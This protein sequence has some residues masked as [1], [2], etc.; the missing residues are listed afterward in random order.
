[1][2]GLQSELQN[3]GSIATINCESLAAV[4]WKKRVV[5][6]NND[7]AGIKINILEK[8]LKKLRV[9]ERCRYVSSNKKDKKNTE[10]RLLSYDKLLE[11]ETQ[12]SLFL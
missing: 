8:S 1:M 4:E 12:Q 3:Q 5:T 10:L 2:T 7:A 11:K 9:V 6:K